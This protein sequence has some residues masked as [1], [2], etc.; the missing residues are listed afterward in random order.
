MPSTYFAL[1]LYVCIIGCTESDK[2]S[3]PLKDEKM[4][5]GFNVQFDTILNAADKQINKNRDSITLSS[6][7]E[8]DFFIEPGGAYEKSDAPLLLKKIDNAKPFTFT[9]ALKPEHRVKYDAGMLFIFVDEKHWVKFAFE[10]DERMNTRIVTVRTNGTS[11]DNNHEVLQ[12]SLV[13]LKISSDTKSIGFYYSTNGSTWNLVRVF[14]NEYP[15]NI[16]VGIG[17]QSPA[18]NGNR[19]VFYGVEFTES[20]VKD[21]RTGL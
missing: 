20:A 21:F 5:I 1:V 4:D 7:K 19:T 17:T 9:A 2:N 18:G 12:D 8:T 16:Y 11:D 6:A 13:L 15:H 14:K 3:L 10:A